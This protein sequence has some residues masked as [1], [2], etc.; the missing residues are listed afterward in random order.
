MEICQGALDEPAQSWSVLWPRRSW[1]SRSVTASIPQ[2][3]PLFWVCSQPMFVPCGLPEGSGRDIL[4]CKW[5]PTV[6]GELLE[7]QLAKQTSRESSRPAWYL[8][9]RYTGT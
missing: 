2:K 4:N 5:Y 7:S 1:V 6:G 3:D 8:L 9:L